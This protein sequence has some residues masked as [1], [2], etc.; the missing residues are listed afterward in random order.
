M[1]KSSRVRER[2]RTTF[3]KSKSMKDKR[4]TSSS[5]VREQNQQATMSTKMKRLLKQY[6]QDAGLRFAERTVEQYLAYTRAFLVWLVSK[7]IELV[8]VRS[9][10]LQAYQNELF[11]SRKAGG[12]PYS[13]S[14]Q[15][16][17]IT[18]LKSFFRFLCRRGLLLHN[19]CSPLELPRSEQRL[20]RTVLTM[21]EVLKIL[22]AVAGEK[23][24]TGL[25]D[26]AILET[27]YATGIRV[28]ELAKLKPYDVDTE[29]KLLR[30]VLGKGQKD[31][32]VPLTQE[33]AS[34]I[35][36]Y[37]VKGRPKLV[38]A[39]KASCLFLGS[40]GGCLHRA[41]LNR[42]V[43]KWVKEAGVKKKATCHSF[44]HSVATHLL[45]GGAD[46]RHIQTLLGHESLSTTERYTRVEIS[47][48]REVVSRAHPRGH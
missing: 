7:A 27:F 30:V 26:R 8:E 18:A 12:R 6:E 36:S 17:H 2:T 10:D 29:E 20:P 3:A 42:I 16:G 37:L 11:A 33:A 35:E 24:P 13:I 32:T 9:E 1:R 4:L 25:R 45:R 39:K 44:R 38:G 28:T 23:S 22:K 47:D 46:I 41:T 48:L 40:R 19:P 34:S 43:Q 31:R 21:R 14:F 5:R 15:A